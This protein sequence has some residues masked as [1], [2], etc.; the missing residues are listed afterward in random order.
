[1]KKQ[2]KEILERMKRVA[3]LNQRFNENEGMLAF[4][5]G[6]KKNVFIYFQADISREMVSD[7]LKNLKRKFKTHY[8][9]NIHY[10][11]FISKYEWDKKAIIHSIVLSRRKIPKDFHRWFMENHYKT[12]IYLGYPECCVEKFVEECKNEKEYKQ[13]KMFSYFSAKRYLKQLKDMKAEDLFGI[14]L[15]HTGRFGF[16]PCSPKCR[17]AIK[18]NNDFER[19]IN[20]LEK[21]KV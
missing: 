8:N 11:Y 20:L 5:F 19:C 17:K 21:I 6:I 14:D 12:G 4:I 16:I 9:T 10:C 18:Y 3:I 7:F 13:E 2:N 15:K 1:M